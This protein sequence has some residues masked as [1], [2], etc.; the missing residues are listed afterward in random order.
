MRSSI[1]LKKSELRVFLRRKWEFPRGSHTQFPHGNDAGIFSRGNRTLKECKK[2]DN[3]N[4]NINGS[5]DPKAK[6][7]SFL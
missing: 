3:L 4:N 1:N 5:N 7:N 2:R 6:V